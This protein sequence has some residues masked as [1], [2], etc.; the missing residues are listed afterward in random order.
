MFGSYNELYRDILHLKGLCSEYKPCGN[1]AKCI[2]LSDKSY[3]CN[4]TFNY[5]GKNCSEKIVPCS[6]NPCLNDGVCTNL[7]SNERPKFNC[8]CLDHFI[9][10]TC[11]QYVGEYHSVYRCY[12]ARAWR[13]GE[14][15]LRDTRLV[16]FPL[17]Y[18]TTG[19]KY[20]GIFHPSNYLNHPI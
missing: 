17:S 4:C 9:G 11:E 5:T 10:T 1:G 6:P 20:W 3:K 8:T 13:S 2:E 12:S 15:T 19:Q 7:Y 14:E 16:S 18:H